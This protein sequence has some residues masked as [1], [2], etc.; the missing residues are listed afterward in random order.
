[1]HYF[2]DLTA[3]DAAVRA[4]WQRALLERWVSENPPGDDAAWQP[5]PTSRR[6]VNWI[7]W[8]LTGHELP[9]VCIASLAV[10]LR[11]L[12][13]RLEYH[14]LGNH[15]LANAKALA[16]GGLFFA[17]PEAERWTA[18][19]AELL[20]AE[21]GEQVLPDGGHFER[22][23]MYHGAV[24]EDLLDLLNLHGAFAAPVPSA[25]SD[26]ARRMRRWLAA[27]THPDG[28]PAFF[29]DVAFGQAATLAELDGYARR[30]G[31]DA[32]AEPRTPLVWLATS[33]YARASVGSAEL[34]CDCAPI[35]PDHLPGHAHADTLSFELSLEARRVFVNSGTSE[36]GT[37]PERVRQRG[38]AAHNT[39]VVDAVDSSEVW[40]GFRV[41]RRA[42][43]IERDARVSSGA[44]VIGAAHDGY[45]GLPGRNVH[46]R[47]WTLREGEL[48]I[49]D[50]IAG[51]RRSAVA[52]F[53][54]HPEVAVRAT[55]ATAVSLEWHGGGA[56]VVFEG[57]DTVA[58]AAGTWHPRFG[59]SLRNAALSVSFS[60]PTLQTHIEWYGRR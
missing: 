45:R 40:G 24:L 54:L 37:G 53:H 43:I 8:A 18:R 1:L 50:E 6:V 44:V 22:S 58:V 20:A 3:R 32:T 35:G 4:E 14:L 39:V 56:S 60:G 31:L 49:A 41:G 51:K 29:N 5:Y 27:M 57:A 23:P 7:K 36:Y 13:C 25:W 15:L 26:T 30:L 2:D 12:A 34:F 11:W 17:G 10:Q 9:A 48:S 52:W 47:T 55:G 59:E 21:L 28:E 16:F 33:G 38:T 46:R 19:A 42:R